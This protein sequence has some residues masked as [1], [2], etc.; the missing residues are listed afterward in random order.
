[1][2]LAPFPLT[3]RPVTAADAP[4]LAQVARA[5]FAETF[6]HLYAPENLA[7]FLEQHTPENWAAQIADPAYAI[8]LV[9]AD[10]TPAGYVKLGPPS[11]PFTPEQGAIE[12][13]QFY[14]LKPH[15]G[16]GFAP[17]MMAWVIAEAQARGFSALYLSVFTENVRARRF[18]ARYAFEEVGPYTFKVGNHEDEDIVMRRAL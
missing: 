7:A 15:H 3:L 8:R 1:M 18:Y 17:E 5:S 13:R 11:L 2:P 16:T 9:E 10:R 14:L 4:A 6:G 12:L